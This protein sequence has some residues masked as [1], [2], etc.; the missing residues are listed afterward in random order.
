MHDVLYQALASVLLDHP[1]FEPIGSS[2]APAAEGRQ[3][4]IKMEV[5]LEM[6][7]SQK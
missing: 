1:A 7:A 5:M 4:G 2:K 3:L 6:S